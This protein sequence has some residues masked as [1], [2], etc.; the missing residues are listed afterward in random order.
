MKIPLKSIFPIL[1]VLSIGCATPSLISEKY[2]P[3][4]AMFQK[5]E[6]ESIYILKPREA[7][8][9]GKESSTSM[10]LLAF[11]PVVPC[12][13]ERLS[14]EDCIPT[15]NNKEYENFTERAKPQFKRWNIQGIRYHPVNLDN[16]TKKKTSK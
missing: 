8:P 15:P 5:T 13:P 10:G 7:R 9:L 2:K 11:I 1:T 3:A 12:A 4:D 16:I 14:P 6:I